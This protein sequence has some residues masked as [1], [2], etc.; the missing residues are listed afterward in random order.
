[1]KRRRPSVALTSSFEYGL[2]VTWNT[3]MQRLRLA[4]SM[5]LIVSGVVAQTSFE[6]I[7]GLIP[8]EIDRAHELV[9]DYSKAAILSGADSLIARSFY[10]KGLLAYFKGQFTL[11]AANYEEALKMPYARDDLNLADRLWNNLGITLQLNGDH[12]KALIAFE[13]SI[14]IGRLQDS[15]ESVAQTKA[16]LG[17][18]SMKIGHYDRAI[19]YFR[20]VESFARE[21]PSDSGLLALVYS[22]LSS[23]F[24]NEGSNPDSAAFYATE[25]IGLYE[26]M[27]DERNSIAA[28]GNL[29]F[30]MLTL[31][32]LS[33]ADT[34]VLQLEDII[35]RYQREEQY[36]EAYLYFIRGSVWFEKGEY[37][38][39]EDAFRKYLAKAREINHF[40]GVK[41]AYGA[42]LKTL[43]ATGDY[44]EYLAVEKAFRR[45]ISEVS[46]NQK[47]VRAD[48]LQ[49]F[50][51]DQARERELL[52]KNAE[53]DG[54]DAQLERILRKSGMKNSWIAVLVAALAFS[55]FVPL[56]VRMF[57]QNDRLRQ[58]ALHIQEV[59]ELSKSGKTPSG[60][61]KFLAALVAGQIKPKP[62]P[63]SESEG[64]FKNLYNRILQEMEEKKLYKDPELTVGKL[65]SHLGSNSVYVSRVI[66]S[67]SGSHFNAFINQ[68]R[69]REVIQMLELQSRKHSSDT[70]KDVALSCGFNSYR[71]FYRSF[72][73]HTG[74]NPNEYLHF[75][76]GELP[77]S[78]SQPS[79]T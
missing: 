73:K 67:F 46:M 2:T 66:N 18:L 5:C 53:L 7:R 68:Y 52:R 74:L 19:A 10:L 55:I 40:Q 56:I 25:A 58:K 44:Q 13:N 16:N 30:A 34:L 15:E 9:E 70:L 8:G 78:A 31:G 38:K 71:T 63:V 28:R 26:E 21:S 59:V 61:P 11:A 29:V 72:I 35:L 45:E 65:S 43:V 47:I 50:Y 23:L 27:A 62:E 20:E 60:M 41:N 39:A 6:E 3:L 76:Q 32:R 37:G 17:L 22:N 1:M 4:L 14:E 33:E 24:I 54:L 77:S 36:N 64:D 42:I 75:L 51:G 12:D 57:H 48:E 79:T 69:I 49:Y